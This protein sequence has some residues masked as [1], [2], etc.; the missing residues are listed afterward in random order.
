MN[1]RRIIEGW[2]DKAWNH[3]KTSREH[4]KQ[5]NYSESIEASQECIELL[6]KS[7]LTFF[8]IKYP[9]RHGWNKKEFSD[10]VNQ[11]QKKKLLDKLK[12]HNLEY[13]KLPRLLFLANFWAQFYLPTKYGFEDGY[14]AT[15]QELF[16]KEEAALA[17]KHAS[18][19]FQA[20][21]NLRYFTQEKINE[22]LK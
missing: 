6:A 1:Q 17:E 14:W 9:K 7:L 18:E 4:L 2:I 20:T 8:E 21:T 3:L 19:C 22:I 10:I 15:S 5:Y 16:G 11:I 13:I 12:E